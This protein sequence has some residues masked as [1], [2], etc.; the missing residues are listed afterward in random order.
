VAFVEAVDIQTIA[1]L[2]RMR[3]AFDEDVE[4]GCAARRAHQDRVDR[5]DEPSADGSDGAGVATG[6][7]AHSGAIKPSHR[8][9]MRPSS[10]EMR[11]GRAQRQAKI[12]PPEKVPAWLQP[13][14]DCRW[15]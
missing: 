7:G 6:G 14:D 12:T 4:R 10:R 8:E 3:P 15:A 2:P 1:R 9:H 13:F 11:F 5:H